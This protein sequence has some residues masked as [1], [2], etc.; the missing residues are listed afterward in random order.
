MSELASLYRAHPVTHHIIPTGPPVYAKAP[1]LHAIKLKAAKQ[2]FLLIFSLGIFQTVHLVTKKNN[3]W[4]PCWD[5]RAQ[6]N[7]FP[8][9]LSQSTHSRFFTATKWQ[10]TSSKVESSLSTPSDT[11]DSRRHCEDSFAYAHCSLPVPRMPIGLPCTVRL[12]QCFI[13]Q[14]FRGLDFVDA[15][16]DGVLITS[17]NP[18]EHKFHLWNIFHLSNST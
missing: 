2:E 13:D 7:R 1:R 12:F 4:R 5:Y 18:D 16:I 15:Y 8:T 10:K 6:S 17:S 11:N 9:S 3:D 14:V